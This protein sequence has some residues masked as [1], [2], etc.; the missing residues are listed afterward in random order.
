MMNPF[1]FQPNH[2]KQS[3]YSPDEPP[4]LISGVVSWKLSVRPHVWRPPTDIFETEDR[5]VVRVEIA[6][7]T[8]A[9]FSV[10]VNNNTLVI[11]G[12]RQDI[13]ER[14]AFHQMEIHFGEFSIEVEF[15]GP[16]DSAGVEAGYQDGFLRVSLPK[17]IP[18]QI[19][20]GD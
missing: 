13:P 5:F 2:M 9:D 19:T 3:G 10:T 12:V 16:V 17:A 6:G 11:H 20:I 1:H 14:R 7:M 4:F 8:D 15:P 18:R